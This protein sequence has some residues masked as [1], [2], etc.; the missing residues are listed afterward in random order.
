M[1]VYL[2]GSPLQMMVKNNRYD[3]IIKRE[4]HQRIPLS[5]RYV[6]HNNAIG[7][8]QEEDSL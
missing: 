3:S 6:G 8:S 5:I 7:R 1:G 4:Y 2:S